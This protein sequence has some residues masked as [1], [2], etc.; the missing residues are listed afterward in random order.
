MKEV[1]DYHEN[2]VNILPVQ[3]SIQKTLGLTTGLGGAFG[4]LITTLIFSRYG[5]PDS[6]YSYFIGIPFFCALIA[7]L[8]GLS[9]LYLDRILLK[10]GLTDLKK[11]GFLGIAFSIL[12]AI[13]VSLLLSSHFGF[14]D[15]EE[16]LPFIFTTFIIGL[17]LG[18]VVSIIDDRLWNMRRKVLALEMKNK[19][20]AELAEKDR[21]LRETTKNL[22]IAEERNRMARDLHDSISQGIHGIIYSAHS[23]KQHLPSEAEQTEKILEHLLITAETTLDELRAMIL[24]LKPSLLK[25][26]GLAEALKLHCELFAK[27]LKIT[28]NLSISEND[29]LTPQQEM[30]VYRIVQEALANIQ[31]HAGADEINVNLF[32]EENN[33]KL[34]IKDNGEGFDIKEI[35]HGNGLDN[36]E[37]RC[38][39]NNGVFKI[40]SIPHAG[41]TIEAIF[42]F[43]K[44]E[45][46]S[47]LSVPD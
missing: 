6:V 47:S 12:V 2:Q 3:D 45:S 16:Q 4:L 25:E 23:L 44:K 34:I 28:C 14:L 36:M 17:V 42:S 31:Q 20:L 39:E 26:H 8:A 22:I 11:R 37:S 18:M 9:S 15:N 35:K 46:L 5:F 40:E 32:S 29:E 7:G 10:L 13:S 38:L 43:L 1:T 41:T 30:A 27:R 24:E 21:Q 19:Y 33:L